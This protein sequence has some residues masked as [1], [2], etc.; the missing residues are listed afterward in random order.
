MSIIYLETF[1]YS[2]PMKS[3]KFTNDIFENN[4]AVKPKKLPTTVS[5]PLLH[6]VCKPA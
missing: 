2:S 5:K 1:R 3:K 6:P 4:V